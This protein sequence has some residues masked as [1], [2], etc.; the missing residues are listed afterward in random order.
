MWVLTAFRAREL[1]VVA[2]V[3]GLLAAAVEG[4]AVPFPSLVTAGPG[5]V[6]AMA[7]LALLPVAALLV[8]W[9]NW[10]APVLAAAVRPWP[11][12]A[13]AGL[14]AVCAGCAA[15]ALGAGTTPGAALALARDVLGCAGLAL[16]VWRFAGRDQA[17][18]AAPVFL[19]VCA[20]AGTARAG[21]NWAFL[22]QDGLVPGSWSAPVALA[23]AGVVAAR[24]IPAADVRRADVSVGG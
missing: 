11:L 3:T 9:R 12:L 19:V 13:S 2:L 22:L 20:V 4:A 1:A 8:A 17:V 16:V 18:A 21:P 5:Q 23:A 14:S 7:L 6:P 10:P 15:V 24:S